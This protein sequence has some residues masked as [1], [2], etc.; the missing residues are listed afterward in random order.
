MSRFKFIPEITLGHI[1]QL[2]LVGI[3]AVA[4]WV[5]LE[6]RVSAMESSQ[7]ELKSVIREFNVSMTT[8]SQNQAV[9]SALFDRH[10]RDQERQENK[11]KIINEN[12]ER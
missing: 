1:I 8:V 9:I 12:L 7:Q 10:T 4:F 2:V 11:Q 3:P 6:S 5:K